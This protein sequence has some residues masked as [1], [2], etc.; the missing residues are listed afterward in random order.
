MIYRVY[1]DIFLVVLP[2]IL[3]VYLI[4]WHRRNDSQI[5]E[6]SQDPEKGRKAVRRSRVGDVLLTILVVAMVAGGLLSCITKVQGSSMDDT[7]YDGQKLYGLRTDYNPLLKPQRGD[8]VVADSTVI[9]KLIVKRVIGVP[10]DEIRIENNRVYVNGILLEEDY[11]PEP[12][13]TKDGLWVLEDGMYFLLGDN[14]NVSDDSRRIGPVSEREMYAIVI[15]DL[16]GFQ[17]Y[18]QPAGFAVLEP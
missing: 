4:I 9:G 1:L 10:G 2:V 16:S 14:R 12:M 15:F 17:S 3:S 7:L 6:E 11:L 18:Q 5:L 13:K 8:I